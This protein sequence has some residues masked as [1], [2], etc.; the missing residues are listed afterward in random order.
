MEGEAKRK[1]E[2]VFK[3]EEGRVGD[4]GMECIHCYPALISVQRCPGVQRLHDRK[5]D[6]P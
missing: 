5:E 1:M 6:L 3:K 2:V 4:G